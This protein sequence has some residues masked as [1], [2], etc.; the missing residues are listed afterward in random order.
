M[1]AN[2]LRNSC[3]LLQFQWTFG[4]HGKEYDLDLDA[5]LTLSPFWLAKSWEKPGSH[6]G[7]WFAPTFKGSDVN[8]RRRLLT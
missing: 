6:R 8:C 3:C 7:T 4:I 5:F 1:V 2:I